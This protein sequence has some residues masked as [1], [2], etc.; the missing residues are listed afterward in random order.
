MEI[1]DESLVIGQ[2]VL[3]DV[4]G[5]EPI[6]VTPGFL[7]VG[8]DGTLAGSTGLN[9]FH[10]SWTEAQDRYFLE[11]TAA[12][13]VAGP[14]ELMSQ[15]QVVLESLAI[16]QDVRLD[17]ETLILLDGDGTARLR[18]TAGVT[19]LP[20][21]AWEATGIN[22]GT[23]AVATGEHTGRAS[24]VFGDGGALT[25]RTG[26]NSLMGGYEAD[27]DSLTFGQIA[28]TRKAG[29]PEL[30]AL[31]EQ[32]LTALDRVTAWSLD[33]TRLVLRDADGSTQVTLKPAG[34]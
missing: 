3:D 29:P 12:T 13:L 32:F 6:G 19:E 7:I 26:V 21:T 23:G 27:G 28:V 15:E 31:E 5:A 1:P 30:M 14:P 25:G 34:E 17:G 22:N 10:G 4:D 9:R 8:A 20:G 24:L 11:V 2:W 16:T 18:Y 33:G